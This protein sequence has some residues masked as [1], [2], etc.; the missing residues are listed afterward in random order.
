MKKEPLFI[1]FAS[2]KGGVG[3]T[4]ITV[5]TASYLHY[6]KGYNVAVV[7]CD[8]PQH[9]IAQMRERETRLA[10]EDSYIKMMVYDHFKSIGKKAYPVIEAKT[11][12][13][14][15]EANNLISENTQDI[16]IVFFDLPGTLKSKGVVETLSSMDYIFAPISADRLV[17]E[18]TMQLLTLFQQNLITTG[19]AK[20]KGL[21]LFWTMVDGREKSSLYNIYEEVMAQMGLTILETFLPDSKKFRRELSS[22]HKAIFRSTFFPIDSSIIKS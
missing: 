19:I 2:P 8:F 20:T 3:K 14:I 6:V 15:D 5:L 10:T 12:E 17:L 21:Y 7:D 13:A 1:A 11:S 4:A 18:S 22:E 9:S 16:D